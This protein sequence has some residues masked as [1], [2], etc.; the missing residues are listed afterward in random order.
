M[1]LDGSGLASA[2][3]TKIIASQPPTKPPAS[4]DLDPFCTAIGEAIVEYLKA[5]GLVIVPAS[6]IVTNG[7]ATTQTG[8]A[9][10]VNLTIT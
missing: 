6:A 7:S 1:P 4:A 3:K 9:T 5:N 10:P 2:I 8:P